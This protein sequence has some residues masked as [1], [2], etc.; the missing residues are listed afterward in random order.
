MNKKYILPLVVVVLFGAGI[1]IALVKQSHTKPSVSQTNSQNTVAN[2]PTD[3]TQATTTPSNT[4]AK[5]GSTSNLAYN[6]ALKIY[7]T[8]YRIQFAECH[9]TPGQLAIRKGVKFM[10]DNRDN[11]NHTIVVKS[12]TFHLAAYGFA[13]VTATDLG[14]YNITCD[15]GGAAQLNV[16]K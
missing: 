12:Q 8:G 2:S 15:G 1:I 10:I 16:Q 5:S 7:G 4:A 14:V 11:V 13:I 9:G 6:E 3:Q